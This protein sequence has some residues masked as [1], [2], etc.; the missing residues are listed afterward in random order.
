MRALEY[1]LTLPDL[2]VDVKDKKGGGTALY[3][4]AKKAKN[5]WLPKLRL[6]TL[7]K[8]DT[9]HIWTYSRLIVEKLLGAVKDEEIASYENAIFLRTAVTVTVC[10]L[11][12]LEMAMY[13]L[14][15]FLVSK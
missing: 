15:L 1:L 10:K 4:A 5:K 13:S 12:T 14:Y 8:D 3:L 9:D 7:F 6:K 2:E 11:L